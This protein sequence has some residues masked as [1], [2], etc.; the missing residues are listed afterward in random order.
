MWLVCRKVGNLFSWR[1]VKHKWFEGIA[2]YTYSPF[3]V[4][5]R[6][7]L[8][9]HKTKFYSLALYYDF[10]T[11]HTREG[12]FFCRFNPIPP[13][14]WLLKKSGLSFFLSFLLPT[15]QFVVRCSNPLPTNRWASPL[16][17]L[18]GLFLIYNFGP[19]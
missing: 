5:N 18:E 8:F 6:G 17:I 1:W 7:I 12:V 4:N 13:C 15:P 14:S 11:H 16:V 19:N 9:R 3:T 10:L 2:Y